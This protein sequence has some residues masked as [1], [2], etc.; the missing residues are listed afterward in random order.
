MNF[1][2]V[3]NSPFL[4]SWLCFRSWSESADQHLNFVRWK[5]ATSWILYGLLIL[6]NFCKKMLTAFYM[7]LMNIGEP[8][9]GWAP[10]PLYP[11]LSLSFGSCV[12]VIGKHSLHENI[13]PD[14]K[15]KKPKLCPWE[16]NGT[17]LVTGWITSS[18][19]FKWKPRL[20]FGRGSTHDIFILPIEF[21]SNNCDAT[22]EPPQH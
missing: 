7:I 20:S 9:W 19:R 3:P 6:N 10:L 15:K 13:I 18:Y 11:E 17:L 12:W 22:M 4:K 21:S 14:K 8:G 5:C 16:G 1:L 2:P